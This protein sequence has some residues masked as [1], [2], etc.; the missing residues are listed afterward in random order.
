M[1][2]VDLTQAFTADMPVFP[3]DPKSKLVRVASIPKEGFTDHMLT[4]PMHVGTHMDAPLHMIVG[5][6]TMDI[7]PLEWFFG[8][9]VLID[10]R[11]VSAV[12]ET[13]VPGSVPNGAIALVYTGFSKKWKTDAYMTGHP[14][15]SES[16]SNRMIELGVHAVG[17]DTLGPDE[18]PFPTLK[19]FWETAS[20]SS[21]I[22]LT[23][24]S[25]SANNST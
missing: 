22:L 20:I 3:G 4:T 14:L 2:L 13:L 5:G 15:I 11:N 9:G 1:H 24:I 19:S 10:A 23:S 16:F 8:P 18:P 12:D 21:K 17:M 25:L 7:I 6:K